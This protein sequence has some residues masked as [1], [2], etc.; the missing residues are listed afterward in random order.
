MVDEI[1]KRYEGAR[2]GPLRLP[3]PERPKLPSEA[4]ELKRKVNEVRRGLLEE[5]KRRV[6]TQVQ[7]I[8]AGLKEEEKLW[9]DTSGYIRSKYEELSG[10]HDAALR[11]A[12]ARQKLELG[13][14]RRLVEG[15]KEWYGRMKSELFGFH[16]A[17]LQ[18]AQAR[19]E[20]ELETM[21]ETSDA[22]VQ[23]SQ[24][25]AE[26]MEQNFSDLFFDVMTGK[27]KGLRDFAEGVLRSLQRATA[28]Y[29][30]QLAKVALFGKK[31]EEGGL[32]QAAGTAIKGFFTK[33]AGAPTTPP[34]GGYYEMGGTTWAGY[35]HSGGVVGATPVPIG[36]LPKRLF[37]NAPR[38]HDGLAPDE[39]PAILQK[40]ETVQ[41]KGAGAAT[42]NI[43]IN[44]VDAKSF[45]DMVRHNPAPIIGAV[46]QELTTGGVLRN[47]MRS[48]V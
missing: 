33:K 38:L 7:L 19:Q 47:T 17:A 27:F 35:Y 20:L 37:A 30:G 45:A 14:E 34:I 2:V 3:V 1:K 32:L 26:A 40:G 11:K 10:F 31:G 5:D 13:G 18:K 9:D 21:K 15:T 12:Q 29:L 41:R 39:F 28:D 42:Y 24:R 22:M 25:T 4:D 8:A 36:T 6:G 23:L 44:A 43:T 16:D 46:Q 48:V